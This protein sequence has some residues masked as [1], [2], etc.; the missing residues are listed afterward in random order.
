MKYKT[1]T[2]ICLLFIA[3]LL[4][5]QTHAALEGAITTNELKDLA[6]MGIITAEDVKDL[7]NMSWQNL[8]EKAE[9]GDTKFQEILG[10][11]YS[12]KNTG[13]GLKWFR[14]AAEQGSSVGQK[15]MGMAYA[16]GEG[17]PQDLKLASEW[18]RKSAEQGDVESQL[19]LGVALMRSNEFAQALAWMD[20]AIKNWQPNKWVMLLDKKDMMQMRD[21]VIALLEQERRKAQATDDHEPSEAEM[22][23]AANNSTLVGE[24]FQ[25]KKHGCRKTGDFFYICKYS[26]GFGI[27]TGEFWKNDG[28]WYFK[29]L[30]Y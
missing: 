22:Q 16:Q 11:A 4:I 14:R 9:K 25:I 26:V 29:I 17:V 13:Q 28:N 5:K 1:L 30:N 15:F 20:L 24:M 12:A 3:L 19:F 18:L 2:L 27:N 23:Q 8:T 10:L 7:E 21:K 6:K